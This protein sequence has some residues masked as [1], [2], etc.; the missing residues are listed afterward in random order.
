LKLSIEHSGFT[1]EK[2]LNKSIDLIR[3]HSGGKCS[4]A[5]SIALNNGIFSNAVNYALNETNGIPSRGDD[6]DDSSNNE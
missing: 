5:I 2:D 1:F 6:D 3:K 4:K